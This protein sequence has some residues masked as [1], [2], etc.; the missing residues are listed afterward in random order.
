MGGMPSCRGLEWRQRTGDGSHKR[1][2]EAMA[3]IF[4]DTPPMKCI[5]CVYLGTDDGR[6]YG[7]I[8]FCSATKNCEQLSCVTGRPEWCPLVKKQ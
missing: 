4:P 3:K 2:Q 5:S 6:D 7:E 1:Y 8:N